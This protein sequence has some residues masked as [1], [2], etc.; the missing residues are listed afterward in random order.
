[1]VGE[2][3]SWDHSQNAQRAALGKSQSV[4]SRSFP[5]SAGHVTWDEYRVKFLAS[6]GFNEK[7]VA[8]KIK[9]N[10]DLKLDEE[11]E[12]EETIALVTFHSDPPAPSPNPQRGN[13][14]SVLAAAQEVL[15]SLK[16]RWFQADTGPTD[17][18]LNEQEFLSFLHPEHSR[19]MLK[20][21]VREIV[22]D[23]GTFS[24]TG[25]P[26]QLPNVH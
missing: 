9:N 24:A 18:L 10:E 6:K 22:R 5:P 21:M 8:E 3:E 11:S 14:V 16:D 23:L 19:G 26:Q 12:W 7:E 4:V 13:K 20:Y 25:D 1:M 2:A 17:Q 15:E